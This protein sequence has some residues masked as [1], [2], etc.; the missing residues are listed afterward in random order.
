MFNKRS[1]LMILCFFFFV[2]FSFYDFSIMMTFDSNVRAFILNSRNDWLNEFVLLFTHV[3]DAKVLAVICLVGMIALFIMRQ[4]REGAL[5]FASL[6]V[7]YGL[8]LIVKNAFGRERPSDNGLI[9]EDGYSFPSGN[10]MVGTSFYLFAAYL[11]YKRYQKPWI[12]WVGILLPLLLGISRVYIGVHFPSDILAGFCFGVFLV[13]CF[14]RLAG[15]Q[16]KTKE[17]VNRNNT[18]TAL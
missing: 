9:E 13:L 7:S 2:C 15:T 6:V 18:N 11:I 8:N 1:Y 3:G 12:L 5:L 14:K 17:S 10:A 4:W 16:A